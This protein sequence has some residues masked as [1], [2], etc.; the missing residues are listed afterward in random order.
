LSK[1]LTKEKMCDIMLNDGFL[2]QFM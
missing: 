2:A 1:G